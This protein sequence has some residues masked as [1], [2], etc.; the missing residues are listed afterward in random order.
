[1]DRH[2]HMD[3]RRRLEAMAAD[4]AALVPGFSITAL[5]QVKRHAI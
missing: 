4:R 2:P 3:N 1:M 5:R